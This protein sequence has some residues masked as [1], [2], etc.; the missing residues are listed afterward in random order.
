[1][2]Y[3]FSLLFKTPDESNLEKE[4][5]ILAQSLRMQSLMA[6]KAWHQEHEEAGHNVLTVRRDDR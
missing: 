6:G 2:Y 5:L 4:G 1:M 3:F